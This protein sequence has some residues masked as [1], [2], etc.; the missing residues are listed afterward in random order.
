MVV[1]GCGT[2]ASPAEVP[3]G[4]PA[5]SMLQA[6]SGERRPLPVKTAGMSCTRAAAGGRGY[7]GEG[8]MAVR[9]PTQF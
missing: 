1:D 6:D 3:P 4:T 9:L 5:P 7:K 2:D 8:V